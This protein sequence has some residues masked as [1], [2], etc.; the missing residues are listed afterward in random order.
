MDFH[1]DM[2]HSAAVKLMEQSA[3]L[4]G[5]MVGQAVHSLTS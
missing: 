5:A 4:K 3:C 1:S 2:K